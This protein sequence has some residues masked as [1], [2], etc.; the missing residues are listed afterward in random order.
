[1]GFLDDLLRG[2]AALAM[3]SAD[4]ERLPTMADA[5]PPA[6]S[7]PTD[8]EFAGHVSGMYCREYA[9]H[10]VVEYITRQL[11]S[12]PLKVYRRNADGD[13]EE[14]RDGNLARLVRH[15]S[16]LP[17]VSRYRFYASLI[18]DMLL[19]DRWLCTL[20]LKPGGD[21]SLRRIPADGYSLTAN[22]FGELTGVTIDSVDG[23]PGGTYR[24]P[25]PN[26]ILDVGYIDGLNIGEPIAN[27]LRPLLA[28]AR[29][30]AEYRRNIAKNGY[31]IPAYVYRPKEMPWISQ[32]DYDDFTQGLRNYVQGGGMAGTWPVFKDGMEIR[33]VDNLF[34]PVDMADLEAREKI[35]EQVALAFH[36]SPENIGF[37]TGTN[38]NIAAYKE[39]LWNVELLPYLVA[40]EEALN[41]TLP[42]AVGE[43]DCY[44]R[45]N[46]DAKLRGTMETQFQALSTATGRPFMTTDEARE[47]LDRPKLPGGDQLITPLNVSEGGQPSPQDGGRT[48]NA[49]Q[50]A[51]PNGKQALAMFDQFR[52]LYRYDAGFRSAWDAM[53]KG[54][55]QNDS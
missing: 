23:N 47:L 35:N 10:V 54:E 29:A 40:F 27:V 46:L 16:G 12:L 48:Q 30:M 50:A 43:P 20:G 14:V 17:G 41:L 39:K 21:Y 18:R 32:D 15:P 11:A 26:V 24:L 25:S 8:V 52:R 49:Q 45:A 2:P 51:S 38:S 9:V 31:Q 36:I 19:E 44:I 1:M 6:I 42:E 7:W 37:R 53:T 5:M 22:G 13:A 4:T 28:E 55:D 33:T 3:K 34:K